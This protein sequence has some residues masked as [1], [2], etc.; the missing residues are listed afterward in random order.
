MYLPALPAISH[1]LGTQEGTAQLSLMSFFVALAV[2]QAIYGPMS[3]ILGRRRPLLF[4]F[5]IDVLASIGCVY[6]P[7]VTVLIVLRFVQGLGACAGMVVARAAARDLYS[8]P[9]VARLFAFMM[10]VLG[11]SPILAPFIGSTIIS[12][13][14][15]SVI[16]W[17][18]A[19]FGAFCVILILFFFEE[20]HA[21]QQ[22]LQGG[23]RPA[24]ATYGRLLLDGRFLGI[25]MASGMIQ[26]GFFAYLAGSP[27]D[28]I[29]LH[30]VSPSM[31]S[32]LFSLNA[33]GLIGM[34]QMN[35]RLMQ[36]YGALLL[37]RSAI[38]INLL[39][40]VTLV[41]LAR[42]HL[43]GLIATAALF[44]IMTTSMGCT[45]P[46]GT[47]LA[48]ER[49]GNVAGSASALIGAV[50]FAVGALSSA[51]VAALFDG[52]SVPMAAVIAGC[53]AASFALSR[54]YLTVR[55]GAFP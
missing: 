12:I 11:V 14:P 49:H 34:A 41:I 10:L 43:D 33:I 55:K 45:S 36:R 28:Y 29:T 44:F 20:T 42:F 54:I 16:F 51:V 37:I 38:L 7:T 26:A 48:L 23:L 27:F 39:A 3:D 2:G 9:E 31:Y 17:V 1:D 30:G 21:P 22:R 18:Q 6:A 53:G 52:S 15:W 50:Q 8:G 47:M 4:G 46:T 5:A 35:G 25:V 32:L 19:A 24:F 40:A 13:A